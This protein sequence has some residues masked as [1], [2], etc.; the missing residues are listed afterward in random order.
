MALPAR[1]QFLRK[2]EKD[3][4]PKKNFSVGKY[5]KQRVFPDQKQRGWKQLI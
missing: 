2:K 4:Y 3:N 5:N 1:Q